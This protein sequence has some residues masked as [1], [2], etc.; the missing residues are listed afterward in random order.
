MSYQDEISAALSLQD[1]EK[2]ASVLLENEPEHG[3]EEDFFVCKALVFMHSGDFESAAAV[4]LQG[5]DRYPD[6][7]DLCYS[8]G[9]LFYNLGDTRKAYEYYQK[10]RPLLSEESVLAQCGALLFEI[11]NLPDF[12]PPAKVQKLSREDLKNMSFGRNF[13]NENDL[14]YLLRRVWFGAGVKKSV[15]S[16]RRGLQNGKTSRERIEKFLAWDGADD[17]RLR[18]ILSERLNLDVL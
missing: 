8:A 7:G 13:E 6:S 2:A 15:E 9:S 4:L 11:E 10:A 14:G 17:R 5:V 16:L 1:T 12:V 3:G 18:K